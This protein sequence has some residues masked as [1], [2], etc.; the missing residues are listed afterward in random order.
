MET[1]IPELLKELGIPGIIAGLIY[2]ILKREIEHLKESF[3]KHINKHETY[4]K[5]V[6]GKIDKIYDRLNPISDAVKKIE[7]Y[8]EA[9]K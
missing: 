6:C 9:K 1:L 2:L 8:M 4:E 5:G 7:G 3:L